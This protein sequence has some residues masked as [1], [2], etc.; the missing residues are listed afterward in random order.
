MRW[1]GE[2]AGR[3]AGGPS[4]CG[5]PSGAGRD[6]G[7]P[8]ASCREELLAIREH[9]D[10]QRLPEGLEPDDLRWGALHGGRGIGGQVAWRA[11]ALARRRRPPAPPTAGAASCKALPAGG[12]APHPTPPT[13]A[14]TPARSDLMESVFF[15]KSTI[16]D[17]S[18]GDIYLGPQRGPPPGL[19]PAFAGPRRTGFAPPGP[20]HSRLVDD[21]RSLSPDRN[22]GGFQRMP[23]SGLTSAFATSPIKAPLAVVGGAGGAAPGGLRK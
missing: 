22:A 20:L 5:C 8:P 2:A 17:H 6:P 19:R 10:C 14:T 23:S 18:A 16:F 3:H 15:D 13:A 21:G 11:Q 1:P 4:G 7:R 9:R 12:S